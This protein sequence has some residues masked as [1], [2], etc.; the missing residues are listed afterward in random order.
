MAQS[1]IGRRLD[2]LPAVKANF[3]EN[4]I[5]KISRAIWAN[6]FPVHR[7]AAIDNRRWVGTTAF[8][9]PDALIA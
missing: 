5:E 7:E 3:S 4:Q 6:P 2:R 8:E 1:Q 9:E